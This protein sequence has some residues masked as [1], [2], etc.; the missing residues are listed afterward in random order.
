[1]RLARLT[2][3]AASSLAAVALLSGCV[4]GVVPMDG[5]FEP[6]Q[7]SVPAVGEVPAQNG[8]FFAGALPSGT[9][10]PKVQTIMVPMSSGTSFQPGFAGWSVGGDADLGAASIGIAF[11]DLGDGYWIV[12]VEEPDE[13]V[14]GAVQWAASCAFSWD[15]PPGPH[16]LDFVAIDGNGNAG[17][18]N[19]LTLT[20]QSSVPTGQ[21]VVSL[22]WDSAADLDLHVVGPPLPAAATG[23]PD[24]WAG[25]PSIVDMNGVLIPGTG[26]IDR[27][28]NAAC[29]ESPL[30]EEDAIFADQPL[31]GT[32]VV[33][34]DMAA[35]CGA[36][37]ANFTVTVRV[38]GKVIGTFEG[39][40]LA[41]QAD[42]G[43]TGTGVFVTNLSF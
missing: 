27:D 32:Y 19:P 43:G 14:S 31:P 40:L 6:L 13:M 16:D 29:V 26:Q 5:A 20:F 10:G 25:N 8:Q 12:P 28:A 34:V 24:L 17:P 37:A 35:A 33:R 1:M 30:R 3:S 38:G 18:K 2:A 39:I 22:T 11:A 15:I 21:V 36:A 7:V 4:E 9:T 41:I 23:S 42:G